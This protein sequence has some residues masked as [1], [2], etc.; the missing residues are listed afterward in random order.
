MT[1]TN[2]TIDKSV[3][4]SHFIYMLFLI[5]AIVTVYAQTQ[6]KLEVHQ[7][8]IIALQDAQKSQAERVDQRFDRTDDKI[9]QV[10]TLVENQSRGR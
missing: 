1:T 10:R 6:S 5:G 8:Q 7:S 4:I 3:N 9:D 2:F